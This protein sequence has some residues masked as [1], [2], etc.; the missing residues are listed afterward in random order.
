MQHRN[1]V[2]S[3]RRPQISC[4]SPDVG[5]ALRPVGNSGSGSGFGF[6]FGSG[7]GSCSGSG[8]GSGSCSGSGEARPVAVRSVE[9]MAQAAVG[10][11]AAIAAL[12]NGLQC[13]V[14]LVVPSFSI[15]ACNAGL[16]ALTLCSSCFTRLNS[17]FPPRRCP[18]CRA[19]LPLTP[20]RNLT[21]EHNRDAMLGQLGF[22]MNPVR[23]SA[24]RLELSDYDSIE[25]RR[26]PG[27]P[28]QRASVAQASDPPGAGPEGGSSNGGRPSSAINVDSDEDLLEDLQEVRCSCT[29]SLVHKACTPCRCNC[30]RHKGPWRRKVQLQ[31]H[32][33]RSKCNRWGASYTQA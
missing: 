21:A 28:Y 22:C 17:C 19:Q 12:A 11:D 13:P 30:F 24:Y 5:D 27:R 23:S 2:C 20:T 8:S 32:W 25:S 14:C 3:S 15:L 9:S 4:R 10:P 29:L 18:L 33:Q 16:C 26:Y 6:G 7:S 1:A 31:Q